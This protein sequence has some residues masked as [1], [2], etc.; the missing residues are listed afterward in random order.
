MIPSSFDIHL[1]WRLPGIP[2]SKHSHCVW[3]CRFQHYSPGKPHLWHSLCP[4]LSWNTR[5]QTVQPPAVLDTHSTEAWPLPLPSSDTLH[6][7]FLP[8]PIQK[9]G[10]KKYRIDNRL[11]CLALM[12]RPWQPHNLFAL[13]NWGTCLKMLAFRGLID[14]RQLSVMLLLLKKKLHFNKRK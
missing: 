8:H 6:Q 12:L 10:E 2:R 3:K 14:G 5:C 7:S 1:M 11:R 4:C 9:E 13:S